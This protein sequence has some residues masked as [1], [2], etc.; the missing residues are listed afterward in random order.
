MDQELT[1]LGLTDTEAKI[2]LAALGL[3]PS[4][5][6]V[7]AKQSGIKRTT[8][9][10]ALDNLVKQGLVSEVADAKE[11]KFKAEEPDRLSKLTRKMRRQVIAAEIEL[12]KLLPGLKAIQKKLIEAP[13][14]AFYQGL[15]GIKTIIEEASEYAEPWYYFGSMAEWMKI[16][17]SQD[18]EELATQTRVLRAKVGKPTN[19][20][21]TDAAYYKVKFFQ[22][23]EPE[24]RQ[25]RIWPGIS[26]AKSSFVIYGKKL[27]IISIGEVPFGAIIESD[28]AAELVKMM[29]EFIW[30]SLPAEKP[31]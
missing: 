18:F 9:Y 22:K 13:R 23:Y 20:M 28:E 27:A 10:S 17:S 29:F 24:I 11:K 7:I 19:Y 31:R 6:S 1:K 25:V 16:L 2:Y 5:A 30:Q 4:A 21:I 14:V 26:K 8:A 3:G 12:E 15:E